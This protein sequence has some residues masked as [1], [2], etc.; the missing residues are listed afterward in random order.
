MAITRFFLVL[1]TYDYLVFKEQKS[2]ERIAPSK[3]NKQAYNYVDYIHSTN[4]KIRIPIALR[5]YP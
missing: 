3:L 1:L 2:F 5:Q 4:R